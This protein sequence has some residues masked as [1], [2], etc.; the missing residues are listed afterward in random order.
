MWVI[1][2]GA[3]LAEKINPTAGSRLLTAWHLFLDSA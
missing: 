3:L 2:A 1:W